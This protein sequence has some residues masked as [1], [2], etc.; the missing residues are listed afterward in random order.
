MNDSEYDVADYK[1]D[2]PQCRGKYR[3]DEKFHTQRD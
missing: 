3:R 1:R 2:W